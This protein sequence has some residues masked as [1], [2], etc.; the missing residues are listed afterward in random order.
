MESADPIARGATALARGDWASAR[1]HFE[2]ALRREETAP[3][4]EGLS[5]ALYWLEEF[6]S[7]IDHR[8]RS[9]ALCRERGDV[10]R[11]ARA[12]IWLARAYFSLYANAAVG[13]GWLRRAERILNEAGDCSERGW[14]VQLRGKVLPDAAAAV[15][16]ARQAVA[17][18]RR[19]GDRDLEVWALSEEGRALVS[20][21]E[22]DEGMAILDEAVAAATAGEA[23]SLLVVGDTCCNML[24]ACDRAADFGRAVE[25]CRVVD[26]FTERHH[27]PPVFHYCR[28]V[29]SGVLIATGRWK[30][31]ENE[32]RSALRTVEKDYPTERVHSLSRLAL[33]CVRQGRL[34]EAGQLLAG[35]ETHGVAV[36][37][38]SSLHLA[39]GEAALADALLERRLGAIGDGLPAAPLLRILADVR[40]SLGDLEGARAAAARLVEIADRSKR[41]PIRAMACLAAARVG[42]ESRDDSDQGFEK[43]CALFEGAGMPFDAAVARLEWAR[44]LAV[45]HRELAAEDARQAMSEFERLGARPFADQAAA[46]LRE[47]GEGTRPGPR[48]SGELT[49]R[50]EEVLGLLSHGLSNVEIGARLFISP[51]T[52][53][54]HVS[55]I[56]S[57]LGLRNRAEAVGWAL[58]NLSPKSGE[59]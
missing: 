31:A 8:R 49:R 23:R 34:E 22:V 2:S 57:K 52:V 12:A 25:W 33:L 6:G 11:A 10:S 58:R 47:L 7:S 40:L 46:M 13:N 38:S 21:G 45:T 26:E 43:A 54:H 39:R 35:L 44:S 48:A 9:Y 5:D 28:V 16:H 51:K 42:L 32:L 37:A 30:E 41:P 50:E 1:S 53:E 59:K 24:S 19:H 3:A 36:E 55:H 56:L 18:A 27:Y 29:Y 17:I 4:L 14:L 20:L 15:G